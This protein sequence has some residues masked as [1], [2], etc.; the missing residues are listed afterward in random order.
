MN[1]LYYEY[2]ETIFDELKQIVV[3]KINMLKKNEIE[4]NKKCLQ[5]FY[6]KNNDTTYLVMVF[7][8]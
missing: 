3:R 1:M 8:T 6:N 2:M 5:R 4:T 7:G